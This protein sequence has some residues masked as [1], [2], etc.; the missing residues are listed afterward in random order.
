MIRR[1]SSTAILVLAVSPAWAANKDIERLHLQVLNLQSQVTELQRK[2]D[3]TLQEMRRLNEI[4]A[5][6]NLALKRTLNDGRAQD[7]ALQ[8]TLKELAERVSELRER[9]Q[10]G[11]SSMLTGTTAPPAAGG[12]PAADPAGGGSPSGGAAPPPRELYSQ[13][14][15]DYARGNFDLSIQGFQEYLKNYP[16]TDFADNAQYWIGE[17]LYGKAQFADAIEAWDVMLRDFPASDKLPDAHVKKAMALDKLGR[18]R[19]AANA[20][21][22]VIEKFPNSSAARIARDKM[23][24]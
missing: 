22:F 7:E 13:A 19:D 21:R 18:K 4:V 14:Y 8:V 12:T 23:N 1:L 10:V 6:Q 20:Y 16:Q 5:E 9:N 15:A 3:E 2:V 17:C 24:P 11:G